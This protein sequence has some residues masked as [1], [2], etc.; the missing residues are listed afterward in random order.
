MGREHIENMVAIPI[1][2]LVMWIS[3]LMLT[4]ASNEVFNQC[5]RSTPHPGIMR[6]IGQQTISSLQTM[7]KMDNFTLV[8]GLEIIRPANGGQQRALNDFFVEDPTDFR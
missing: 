7:D 8:N 4:K 1:I 5:I 3:R 6:C 2:V